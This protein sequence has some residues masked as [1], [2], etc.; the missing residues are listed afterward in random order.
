MPFT[1]DSVVPWGRSFEEYTRMFVLSN[2]DLKQ[3]ILGW[4]DGPA[5]FKG[6]SKNRPFP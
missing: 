5:S 3:R 6:T 2:E 1:L 4:S